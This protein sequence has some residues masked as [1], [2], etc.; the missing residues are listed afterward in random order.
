MMT[1]SGLT[2]HAAPFGAVPLAS[3][4]SALK[5]MADGLQCQRRGGYKYLS[6]LKVTLNF[7]R[8]RAL[9]S[10]RCGIAHVE[11]RARGALTRGFTRETSCRAGLPPVN[12]PSGL[13]TGS[14]KT[15]QFG[16]RLQARGPD[17]R[18]FKRPKSCWV[19]HEHR[20]VIAIDRLPPVAR[21][22]VG[23]RRQHH[24]ATIAPQTDAVSAVTGY[25]GSSEEYVA[26]RRGF[27]ARPGVVRDPDIT[28]ADGDQG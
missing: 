17:D 15:L 28:G 16:C 11:S 3:Q 25:D 27:D 1:S 22:H 13:P 14:T 24:H 2:V 4:G 20:C 10:G 12:S 23:V 26:A 9:E 5:A 7:L 21:Q 6:R 8:A 18:T 19:A